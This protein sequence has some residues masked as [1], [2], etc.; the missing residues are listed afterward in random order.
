M[1]AMLS[2]QATHNSAANCILS[3]RQEAA[4]TGSQ[5]VEK[6]VFLDDRLSHKLSPINDVSV[7]VQE[8]Q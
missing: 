7:R 2:L 5:L 3:K 8:A 1:A 6:E 4:L